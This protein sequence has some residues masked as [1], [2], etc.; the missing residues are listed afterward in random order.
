MI[1]LGDFVLASYTTLRIKQ[2][3]QLEILAIEIALNNVQF[4]GHSGGNHYLQ[5]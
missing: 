5:R 1:L 3:N 4:V 2:I